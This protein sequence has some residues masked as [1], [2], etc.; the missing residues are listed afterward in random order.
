MD[1]DR[2]FRPEPFRRENGEDTERAAETV[3][4]SVGPEPIGRRETIDNRIWGF[5]PE[6][7]R[8]TAYRRRRLN[9][10]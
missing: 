4:L 1:S 7:P 5:C 6:P 8:L 2:F 9:F 3:S 10:F